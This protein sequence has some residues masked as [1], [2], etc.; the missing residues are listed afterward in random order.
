MLHNTV[1]KIRIDSANKVICEKYKIAKNEFKGYVTTIPQEAR[2]HL[3]L[4]FILR[5]SYTFHEF[6]AF[7]ERMNSKVM[8]I[9]WICL[10]QLTHVWWTWSHLVLGFIVSFL[11]NYFAC[12]IIIST[13]YI[14][15]FVKKKIKKSSMLNYKIK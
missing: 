5:W 13:N 4:F 6:K 3:G 1:I 12:K 10:Y 9:S 2:N 8:S 11:M 15:A 7:F 14:H